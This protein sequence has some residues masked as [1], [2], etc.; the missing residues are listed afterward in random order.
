[1]NG[2][3]TDRSWRSLRATPVV[4]VFS[5][6]VAVALGTGA[7]AIP[8][9]FQA[10]TGLDCPFCGGSRALGA[11]LEG[12]LAGALDH[13]LFAVVVLLPLVAVVLVALARWEAGRAASWWPRGAPG[14]WSA[15]VLV[16][17][18]FMWWVVRVLPVPALEWLRA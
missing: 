7:L 13:N 3:R 12:D 4:V 2:S 11:L 10:A 9:W 5:A 15:V 16:V 8:C 1:M 18:L 14:R 6:V 17:L